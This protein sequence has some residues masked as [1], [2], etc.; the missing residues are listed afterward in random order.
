MFQ[1]VYAWLNERLGLDDIYSTV[2]DRKV[3]KNNWWF[4]LGSVNLFLFAIQVVTGMLL[5]VYYVPSPD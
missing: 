1:N 5:T 4:T 2:L 3:P